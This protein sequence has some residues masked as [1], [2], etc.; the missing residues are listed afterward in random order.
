MRPLMVG[1][2]ALP[3]R[4]AGFERY[5]LEVMLSLSNLWAAWVLLSAGSWQNII[6]ARSALAM[7]ANLGPE[8]HWGYAALIGATT[9]IVGLSLCRTPLVGTPL[10]LRLL[11]IA[12][13]GAFWFILGASAIY[14][15]PN[16]LFG[17]P[18]ML[19]GISAWWL[20]IRLPPLP[21]SAQPPSG[22]S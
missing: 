8:T 17:L 11:G 12:I 4:M 19:L 16:A 9:T 1:L 10:V 22:R 7:A 5:A 14:G 20:L 13:S 21:D 2:D 3:R 15:N 6:S 18:I